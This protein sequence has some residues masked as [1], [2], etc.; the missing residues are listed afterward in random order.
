MVKI[1]KIL[2]MQFG[3]KIIKKNKNNDSNRR[4]KLLR[5][6]NDPLDVEAK[7]RGNSFYFP[8]QSYSYVSFR[9]F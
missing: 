6:E 1:V 5:K 7:K 2:M 3:R 4:R 8:R 9:D